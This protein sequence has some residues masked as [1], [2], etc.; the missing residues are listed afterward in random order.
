MEQEVKA[1]E[2]EE[3]PQ[4]E[5]AL[6]ALF[7]KIYADADEDTRRAM[8]KSFQMSGGTCLSTNWKEVKSKSYEDERRGV[9]EWDKDKKRREQGPSFEV[10]SRMPVS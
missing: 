8:M 9:F 1:Q 4:G 3:K 10:W 6:N 7:Q 2:E 5:Q